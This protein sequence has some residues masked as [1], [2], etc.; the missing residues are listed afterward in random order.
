MIYCLMQTD[1]RCVKVSYV[2][3]HYYLHV[4]INIYTF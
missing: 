2:V 4:L 3:N 1:Y